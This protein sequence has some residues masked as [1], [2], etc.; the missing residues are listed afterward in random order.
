MGTSEHESGLIYRT[1]QAHMQHPN[2]NTNTHAPQAGVVGLEELGDA[3]ED[4]GR[5][6]A[7]QLVPLFPFFWGMCACVC[8]P[9]VGRCACVVG[10]L[11]AVSLVLN[12][13]TQILFEPKTHLR[14]NVQQLSDELAAAPGVLGDDVGVVKDAALL[15]HRRLLQVLIGGD[16]FV[17]VY[18]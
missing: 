16:W 3:E 14:Q 12:T 18:V 15:K 8:V 9:L 5:L 2:S 7:R 4:G 13:H 10:W 17:G 11:C 6:R 1:S